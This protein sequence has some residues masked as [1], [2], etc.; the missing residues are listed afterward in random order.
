MSPFALAGFIGLS[1]IVPAPQEAT[2][3]V[4]SI[5][6][7]DVGGAPAYRF[8]LTG[9]PTS[10]SATPEGADLVVRIGVENRVGLPLPLILP[11]VESAEFIP[12]PTFALRLRLRGGARLAPEMVRDTGSLLLVLRHRPEAE[13]APTPSPS[14]SARPEEPASPTPEPARESADAR[15]AQP[16]AD[17]LYRI[18]FPAQPGGVAPAPD[19]TAVSD[20]LEEDW[21]SDF[22]FL[23]LQLK[24]WVSASWV[25]GETRIG[26]QAPTRDTHV[27]VQ[28]NLG[29]GF[30]PEF[31]PG[32]GRWRV[33]YT[34]RFRDQIDVRIPELTSHFFDANVDQPVGA[35]A[36]LS[37]SYH[38][39]RG[40]LDT[41]EVDPGR[42][43]GIGRQYVVDLDLKPFRRNSFGA[44]ARFELT[45]DFHWDLNATTTRVSYAPGETN[46]AS[47]AFFGYETH[48]LGTSLRRA[49]GS[50]WFSLGY[51]FTDTP[52]PEERPEAESRAH[53]VNAGVDGEISPLMTGRFSFGYRS[54]NS[55]AA[56]EGGRKYRDLTYGGQL[57]RE[58]SETSQ[59]SVSG[60]R[61]VNLSAYGDNAFYVADSA[62]LDFSLRLPFSV[63]ARAGLAAQWNGYRV[64]E[65]ALDGT[66]ARRRDRI[67]AWNVGL[68]RNVS[69]F[70]YLRADYF[71][72]RRD[73]NLDEFDVR[74]RAIVLQIAVGAFGRP[75]ASRFVW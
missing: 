73:S 62:R 5:L 63:S 41:Q 52:S 53:A 36:Q 3:L 7:E 8:V 65:R 68:V 19:V 61:R 25:D 54:Q 24:P 23:G 28:P 10:Y 51:A 22:R 72:E 60:D 18:L 12:G 1:G 14:P 40:V 35:R 59:I 55:P 48:T 17:D 38:H 49:F 30:S 21:Y 57:Q 75:D 33:N 26:K 27:L 74:S 50:R 37:F 31:G 67:T 2:G 9:A 6:A 44:A 29:I 70:A 20:P 46:R 69:R 45:S 11:P 15:D 47:L 34:P 71:V 58:L 66:T 42:E 13:A 32:G 64:A 16:S 39:S 43:Y 56:G 4:L